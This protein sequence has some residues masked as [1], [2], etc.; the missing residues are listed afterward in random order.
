MLNYKVFKG[1]IMN[2]KA[3]I[4]RVLELWLTFWLF[5]TIVHGIGQLL[6]SLG[7]GDPESNTLTILLYTPLLIMLAMLI[8][9]RIVTKRLRAKAEDEFRE[10]VERQLS[11]FKDEEIPDRMT[12]NAAFDQ[13]I[14]TDGADEEAIATALKFCSRIRPHEGHWQTPLPPRKGIGGGFRGYTREAGDIEIRYDQRDSEDLA[15]TNKTRV[16]QY[17][18]WREISAVFFQYFWQAELGTAK[19]QVDAFQGHVLL[20]HPDTFA[21]RGF[22][23]FELREM[24][25][26]VSNGKAYLVVAKMVTGEKKDEEIPVS[27]FIA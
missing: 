19:N 25:L 9:M 26:T 18:V 24:P 1:E 17:K 16:G 21:S 10:K 6:A 7:Y 23:R 22:G 8:R 20:F 13:I 12:V 14:A 4:R 15:L 11:L 5:D 2:H 3:L 27:V